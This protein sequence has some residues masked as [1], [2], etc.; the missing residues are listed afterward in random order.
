[1]KYISYLFAVLLLLCGAG[2]CIGQV[3]THVEEQN[4]YIDLGLAIAGTNYERET[5]ILFDTLASAPGVDRMEIGVNIALYLRTSRTGGV[6]GFSINGIGDRLDDGVD[7]IQLNQYL[8]SISQRFY[9]GGVVGQGLFF[10]GDIGLAKMAL[11]TSFGD[12]TSD[13]GWGLLVGGGYSF[14]ISRGS[15]MSFS[16]EYTSKFIEEENVGGVTVGVALLL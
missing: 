16:L 11:D 2:V 10:R 4:V 1:M 13:M 6:T 14:T 7:H 9:I 15:W 5:E 12:A 3:T 8:Y